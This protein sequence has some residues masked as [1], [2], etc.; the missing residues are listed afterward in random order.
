MGKDQ[1]RLN[2]KELVKKL[3]DITRAVQLLPFVYGFLFVIAMLVYLFCPDWL[4]T[5]C[6]HL[7]YVSIA[8]VIYNLILSRTLRLC[9]WHRAACCIPLLPEFVGLADKT[10]VNLS[11]YA[12]FLNIGTIITMTSLLL[13]SAYKVFFSNGR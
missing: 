1:E 6:D 11:Q 13:I 7:F 3:R 10:I 4:S 2:L 12:E 8:G 5:I 9:K